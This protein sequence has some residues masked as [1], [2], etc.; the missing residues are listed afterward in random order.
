MPRFD[1]LADS[2]FGG[3]YEDCNQLYSVTPI[4]PSTNSYE[5]YGATCG[6]RLAEES[7]GTCTTLD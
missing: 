6:G 5:G 7:P 2:C 3:V 1:A 4:S